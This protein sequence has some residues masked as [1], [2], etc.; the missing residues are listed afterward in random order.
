MDE[1]IY[2]WHCAYALE[3]ADSKHVVIQGSDKQR[4]WVSLGN[5]ALKDRT[6]QHPDIFVSNP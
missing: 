6:L 2:V 4:V 1:T 3:W 5:P